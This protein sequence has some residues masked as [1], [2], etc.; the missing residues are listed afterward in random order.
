MQINPDKYRAVVFDLDGTLYNNKG[1]PMK[2]ILGDLRNMWVLGAERKARKQIKGQDYQSAEGVYKALFEKMAEVKKSRTAEEAR[3]WYEEKYMPLQV[4]VLRMYFEARP[5]VTELL[6]AMRN[7]GLKC[8]LY[9]DYGHEVE[10]LQALDIDPKL[11]DATL[12]APELGGLKPSR[13]SM[14]RL[15]EKFGL[16]A[17]TTLY[18]G[19]RED[20]DGDSA[21]PFGIDFV[22]VKQP[23]EN[24]DELLKAFL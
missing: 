24:W 15:M 8:I 18:V 3:C 22:N 2:L 5:L 1:L 12:S 19:D 17:A 10:K 20:T 13:K 7:R 16:D 11:F 23:K 21:R 14:E 6:E 4:S 9:S